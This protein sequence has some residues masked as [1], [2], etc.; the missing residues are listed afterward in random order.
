MIKPQSDMLSTYT[1]I[2]PSYLPACMSAI[3]TIL[4]YTFD[5][6]IIIMY[7]CHLYYTI[8]YYTFDHIIIIM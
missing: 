6:I 8:L 2:Q 3:Y 4:Y 1:F 7:E 5:H